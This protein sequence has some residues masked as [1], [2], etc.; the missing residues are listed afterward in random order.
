MLHVCAVPL[1]MLVRTT[2]RF[3][4]MNICH[5]LLAVALYLTIQEESAAQPP[6]NAG[7]GW[8]SKEGTVLLMCAG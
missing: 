5:A 1:V 3:K 6:C 7:C 4:K 2:A 8:S